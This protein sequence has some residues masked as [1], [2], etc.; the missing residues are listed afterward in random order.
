MRAAMKVLVTL[1]GLSILAGLGCHLIKT[2]EPKQRE[3]WVSSPMKYGDTQF[4]GIRPPG[5]ADA[6]AGID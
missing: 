5:Y 2:E 4:E 1:V 6:G 3:D